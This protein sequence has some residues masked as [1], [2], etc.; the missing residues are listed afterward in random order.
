MNSPN[1]VCWALIKLLRA[2]TGGESTES[3]LSGRERVKLTQAA[4][5]E[6]PQWN[7]PLHN[8]AHSH[9]RRSSGEWY[10]DYPDYSQGVHLLIHRKCGGQGGLDTVRSV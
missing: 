3:G 1:I 2:E 4:P 5:L 10:R 8:P 7:Q 9:S 6:Q